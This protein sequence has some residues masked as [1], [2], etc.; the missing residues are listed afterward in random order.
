M[1][2][3]VLVG[4]LKLRSKGYV[5]FLYSNS[6]LY[7]KKGSP[8]SGFYASAHSD[9]IRKYHR[10]NSVDL[11]DF[12]RK[13]YNIKEEDSRVIRVKATTRRKDGFF[14]MTLSEN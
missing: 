10:I 6:H 9:V 7:I 13:Y 14:M 2:N 11:L 5:E 1:H 12:V 4:I 8:D 3:R